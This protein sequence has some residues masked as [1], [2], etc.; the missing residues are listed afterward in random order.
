LR[1]SMKS[2]MLAFKSSTLRDTL[3]LICR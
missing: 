2:S 3:R 1:V